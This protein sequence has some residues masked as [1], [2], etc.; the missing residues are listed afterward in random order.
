MSYGPLDFD[1][2]FV[3]NPPGLAGIK[4]ST[5][6][7][8]R[9]CH[10]YTNSIFWFFLADFNSSYIVLKHSCLRAF[11]EIRS[12][13][14]KISFSKNY[15]FSDNLQFLKILYLEVWNQLM[16]CIWC[17]MIGYASLKLEKCPMIINCQEF[18]FQKIAFLT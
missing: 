3:L 11:L 16:A 5:L 14:L 9:P 8:S 4:R 13:G 18:W 1:L 17:S 15:Q 2:G 6:I 12:S 7:A 10:Y